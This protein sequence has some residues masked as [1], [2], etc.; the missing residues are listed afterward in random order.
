MD[1]ETFQGSHF[2]VGSKMGE[3]YAGKDMATLIDAFNDIYPNAGEIY[4]L[5]YEIYRQA[6]PE[7]VEQFRGV[8]NGSGL[9]KQKVMSA[10]MCA[11]ILLPRPDAVEPMN[12]TGT[13][14]GLIETT[15]QVYEHAAERRREIRPN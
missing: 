5:Q 4:E 9:D 10:M 11:E 15:V 3:F 7:L 14:S 2:D 6:F 13:S 12:C 8:A 1:T